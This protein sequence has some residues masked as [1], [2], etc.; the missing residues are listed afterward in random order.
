MIKQFIKFRLVHLYFSKF[1][2]ADEDD[3]RGIA[4][5]YYINWFTAP[6]SLYDALNM[7]CK[8]EMCLINGGWKC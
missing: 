7:D 8:V 2:Y 5:T 6:M 4:W 1:V 3:I